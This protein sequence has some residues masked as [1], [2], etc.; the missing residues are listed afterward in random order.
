[1]KKTHIV[2]LILVAAAI[3]IVV[4][5]F[6]DFSTYETFASAAQKPNTKFR[7]IGYLEK[8]KAMTY[9]PKVDPNKFTFYVKDKLGNV[10][11]VVF[12]GAKPTDIE[13][14]E[15][16][17]M[18]GHMEGNVFKCKEIQMKCPSKYKNDQIATGV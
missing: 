5:M 8:D 7:V 15:Q 10:N 12:S 6:A 17:V 14:S 18:T 2:L 11:E 1:M 3:S 13:K 16:I 4:V 9:D